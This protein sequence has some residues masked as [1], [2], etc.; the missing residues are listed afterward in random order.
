VKCGRKER[1]FWEK[2]GI[3]GRNVDKFGKKR[4]YCHK[5]DFFFLF[6]EKEIFGKTCQQIA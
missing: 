4:R 5:R 2:V 6:V 3:S 1:V